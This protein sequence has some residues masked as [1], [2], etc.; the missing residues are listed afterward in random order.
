MKAEELALYRDLLGAIKARGGQHDVLAG[1]GH[2]RVQPRQLQQKQSLAKRHG[3]SVGCRLPGVK[4]RRA[5]HAG[6]T[7]ACTTAPQVYNRRTWAKMLFVRS[8]E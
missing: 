4:V 5:L 7:N 2:V 8:S 3:R 1:R 6:E